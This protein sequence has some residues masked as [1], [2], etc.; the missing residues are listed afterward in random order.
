MQ[1]LHR[2]KAFRGTAGVFGFTIT[3]TATNVTC[4]FILDVGAGQSIEVDWGDGSAPDTY[5]TDGLKT[6]VYAAAGTRP[7]TVAGACVSMSWYGI[8]TTGSL[9]KGILG[10]GS[11]CSITSG[12]QMF[13]VCTGI[14]GSIPPL[15]PGLTSA[16]SMFLG[17]SGLTGAVPTLPA[18]LQYASYMFHT[19]SGLTGAVPALPPTL[20]GA[21]AMFYYCTGLTGAVPDFPSSL[22]YGGNMFAGCSGLTGVVPALPATLAEAQYMFF[23]CTGIAGPLPDM[24][25]A[26]G[27]LENVNMMFFGCTGL[28]GNSY[29]FWDWTDTPAITNGCYENCTNLTDY[30]DIP[31]AYK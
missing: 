16:T 8:G 14:T 18:T 6:H 9:V 28:T 23:N 3:T 10:L 25:A 20:T 19:C 2:R 4:G 26:Q 31:A 29:P 12:Y 7:L 22:I 11:D 27:P 21:S 13:R 17:C 15:P 1:L 24:A 30:A 5:S